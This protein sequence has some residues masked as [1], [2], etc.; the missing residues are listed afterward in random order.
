M[1]LLIL[2]GSRILASLVRRLVPEE[3]AVEEVRTFDEALASLHEA[4]PDALIVNL[5]PAELP[6]G[7]LK[8]YCQNHRPK[9]PVLFESCV[10]NSPD[11]A[12]IGP[13]NHSARFLTKPYP[14]ETLRQ[15]LNHLLH[16]RER[17]EGSKKQVS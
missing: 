11:E 15:E 3:V 1:R 6:W 13:L 5:A 9:I 10:Y 7:E 14:V 8:I 4:P 17:T 12:G 16:F 2:D